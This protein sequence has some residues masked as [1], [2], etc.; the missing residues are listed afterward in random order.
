VKV[1]W[2]IVTVVLPLLAV[3]II[4]T[5]SSAVFSATRG[6]T[7]IAQEF[8]G[9]KASE[10]EKHANSQW[11]LLVENGFTERPDMVEATKNGV[12]TFARSLLRN[13]TELIFA[14]DPEGNL[15]E[16]T[17]EVRVSREERGALREL[18]N[19]QAFGMV[20]IVLGGVER[21]GTWSPMSAPPSIGMWTALSGRA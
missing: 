4:L 19:S 9:F 20:D 10:L 15:V 16:S 2:K 14:V 6:I 21:I 1:R 18:Y 3:T 17:A 8:L 11:A 12:T 5:G 13:E 7:R